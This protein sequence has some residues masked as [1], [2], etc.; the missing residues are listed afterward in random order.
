M[1]SISISRTEPG[2]VAVAQEDDEDCIQ[3]RSDVVGGVPVA[4]R[5]QPGT[6]QRRLVQGAAGQAEGGMDRR[7]SERLHQLLC[8]T[9]S[10]KRSSYILD[11]E[12]DVG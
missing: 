12:F 10:L 9:E 5:L 3:A 11:K 1:M 8:R 4:H 6:G 7:R 2:L